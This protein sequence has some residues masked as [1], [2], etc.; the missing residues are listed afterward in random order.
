MRSLSSLLAAHAV[1]H[2]LNSG[3]VTASGSLAS[4]PA[5][6]MQD[7]TLLLQTI[8]VSTISY[9]INMPGEIVTGAVGVKCT[10][11]DRSCIARS[12]I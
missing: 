11:S 4:P 3:T 1:S 7:K 10:G 6:A 8:L 2:A 5:S 9:I 12:R